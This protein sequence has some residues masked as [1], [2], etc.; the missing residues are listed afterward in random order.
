MARCPLT[1]LHMGDTRAACMHCTSW[2]RRRA[3]RRRTRTGRHDARTLRCFIRTRG[4][5]ACAAR[6]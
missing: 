4:L 1:P 2:M 6:A 3:S 5:P